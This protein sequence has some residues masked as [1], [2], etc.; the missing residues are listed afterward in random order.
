MAF[1][2]C[3]VYLFQYLFLLIG[4]LAFITCNCLEA[5]ISISD[6][7]VLILNMNHYVK[8]VHFV[9]GPNI[10]HRNFFLTIQCVKDPES[11]VNTAVS[12]GEKLSNNLCIGICS[13][14]KLVLVWV[15]GI[16]TIGHHQTILFRWIFRNAF[17]FTIFVILLL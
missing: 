10:C 16:H 11:S 3:I 6:E 7:F 2:H 5:M 1:I 12:V 17:I 14:R 9:F 4:R 13:V 15:F 8:S